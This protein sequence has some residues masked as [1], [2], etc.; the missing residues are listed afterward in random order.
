MDCAS[1][2]RRSS[3]AWGWGPRRGGEAPA[4]GARRATAPG[5]GEPPTPGRTGGQPARRAPRRGVRGRGDGGGR[6]LGVWG[7]GWRGPRGPRMRTRLGWAGFASIGSGT[8]VSPWVDREVEARE[9]LEDLGLAAAARSF[10]ALP[11]GI[12]DVGEMV[13]STWPLSEI[14]AAYYAFRDRFDST[15]P[16]SPSSAAF[17]HHELLAL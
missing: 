6:R 2:T 5:A 15:P 12:G 10:I 9:V 7:P 17:G 16:P 8:W 1:S 11:G 3:G 14:G 13:S 4:V